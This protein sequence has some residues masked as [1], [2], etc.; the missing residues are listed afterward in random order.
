VNET[1]VR[2]LKILVVDSDYDFLQVLTQFLNKEGHEVITAY[3]GE[4]GLNKALVESPDLVILEPML[5]KIHGFT[6]CGMI[7]GEFKK[8]IPVIIVSQHYTDEN[9]KK[10]ALRTHGASAYMV[11]PITKSEL[12]AVMDDVIRSTRPEADDPMTEDREHPDLI[13]D[14]NGVAQTQIQKDTETKGKTEPQKTPKKSDHIDI[15]ELLAAEGIIVKKP[16]AAKQI[17]PA[18]KENGAMKKIGAILNTEISFNK[19]RE[20]LR[21]AVENEEISSVHYK[22]RII[23]EGLHSELPSENKEGQAE[24]TDNQT[25][26]QNSGS[27]DNGNEPRKKVKVDEALNDI[28][29]EFGLSGTGAEH[30]A[31]PSL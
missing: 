29:N 15:E 6:L 27:N 31:K 2:G 19:I 18:D 4:E 1:K 3:D 28:M 11:R 9:F 8:N 30:R 20:R 14:T 7:S 25:I 5:S 26:V 21:S 22:E 13:S 16:E 17:P 12:R 24:T 10:E 23:P